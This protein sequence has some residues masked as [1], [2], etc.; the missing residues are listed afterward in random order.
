MR[1]KMTNHYAGFGRRELL[2]GLPAGHEFRIY[3]HVQVGHSLYPI[4]E[5]AGHFGT[6]GQHGS[7]G[8]LHAMFE[9]IKCSCRVLGRFQQ[10]FVI[11]V[12]REFFPYKPVKNRRVSVPPALV[13]GFES[14][15]PIFLHHSK[16]A[17]HED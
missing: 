16:A 6:L 3:S 7:G 11:G 4:G 1:N 10:T 14:A 5:D 13:G 12:L 9:W 2:D 8:D 15:T 17:P